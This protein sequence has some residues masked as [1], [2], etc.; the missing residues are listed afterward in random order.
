MAATTPQQTASNGDRPEFRQPIY[1]FAILE[2]A[3]DVGDL[4]T[5]A[6][7]QNRLEGLGVTVR[8]RRR[9]SVQAASRR[10]P[11]QQSG[12]VGRISMGAPGLLPNIGAP[13]N[14]LIGSD[15]L[16]PIRVAAQFARETIDALPRRSPSPTISGGGD[17]P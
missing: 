3:L 13:P 11:K 6:D 8:F 1:W 17:A 7:A 16:E 12:M 14:R 2:R 10:S 4:V 5:A 9:P 15:R